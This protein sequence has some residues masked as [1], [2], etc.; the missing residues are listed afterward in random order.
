MAE[1]KNQHYVPQSYLEGFKAKNLPNEWEKTSAIWVLD[2]ISGEI[3]LK[4]IKKTA[5]KNYYYSFIDKN[6][7][8]NNEIE[9]CFNQIE[10]EYSL[11]RG[12]IKNLIEEI[13]LSNTAYNINP[14]YKKLISEYFYIQM[15]RVPRVFE[16]LKGI[17][18][19]INL[20]LSDKYNEEYDENET[21][22]LTLR[23]LS[24]VGRYKNINFYEN[25]MK[26]TLYIEYFP[27]T[28]VSIATSDSPIM[29]YD[30]TR[31]AGLAY[32]TTKI[33]L[34]LGPSIILT[35]GEFG[36]DI[37]ILKRRELSM[38]SDF[39][40]LIGLKSDKEIYSNN[41]QTLVNIGERIGIKTKIIN[42]S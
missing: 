26:R 5:S 22:I 2:K 9:K 23:M 13:N 14:K 32:E 7:E 31:G 33:C 8:M 30:E 29:M 35:L 27:R 24:K 19:N 28:K 4:S 1:Y 15:I 11:I 38:A 36:D 21:Q 10:K 25:F 41:P 12:T 37:K 6:H 17:A 40:N 16:E 34:V 42:K 18:K 3:R 20:S 39:N